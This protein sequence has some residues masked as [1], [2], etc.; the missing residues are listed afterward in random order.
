M[1]YYCPECKSEIKIEFSDNP[2]DCFICHSDKMIKLPDFE[3]PSQ[4][5]KRTGKRWQGAV[6]F[7][8]DNTWK[9]NG[10]RRTDWDIITVQDIDSR[11]GTKRVPAIIHN[12]YHLC[13]TSPEPPPDNYV[14][15]VE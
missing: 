13:A 15:E 12:I 5:E 9:F 2:K 6:W 8:V 3:T 7:G 10:I 1:Q 4:Y 11:T 14:P